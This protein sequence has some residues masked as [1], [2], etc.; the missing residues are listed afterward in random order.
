MKKLRCHD[1]DSRDIVVS[2][3]HLRL[4]VHHPELNWDSWQIK[5]F[6]L[7]NYN[8]IL[9]NITFLDFIP[10]VSD[11]FSLHL[12][13]IRHQTL[14]HNTKTFSR[15][16]SDHLLCRRWLVFLL[17]GFL[18]P[19]EADVWK[20]NEAPTAAQKPSQCTFTAL[21]RSHNYPLKALKIT[22]QKELPLLHVQSINS[23]TCGNLRA[24]DVYTMLKAFV[25]SLYGYFSRLNYFPVM[26]VKRCFPSVW[27]LSSVNLHI[28]PSTDAHQNTVL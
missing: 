24:L 12:A 22:P 20:N 27:F 9:Y 15:L 16:F 10:E 28:L 21:F 18:N 26:C 23:S 1:W 3:C 25:W 6:F 13:L 17:G 14:L 7:Y 8:F 11:L 2:S 19:F 4:L 5:L